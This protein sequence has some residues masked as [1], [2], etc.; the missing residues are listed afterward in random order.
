MAGRFFQRRRYAIVR[1]MR[2]SAV[3]LTFEELA[4]L[5]AE[6]GAKA[7]RHALAAGVPVSGVV[8]GHPGI[9]TLHPDGSVT[10]LKADLPRPADG[11][12]KTSRKSRSFA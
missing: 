6:A 9:S 5:G 12:G 2:K 10:P 1:S 7:V 4:R 3:D 11:R 8:D